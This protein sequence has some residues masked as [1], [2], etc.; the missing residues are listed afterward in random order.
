MLG[1]RNLRH[2]RTASINLTLFVFL[3]CLLYLLLYICSRL[4]LGFVFYA[5]FFGWAFALFCTTLNDV[6]PHGQMMLPAAVMFTA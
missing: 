1:N 5:A 4:L 6:C 3:S 2:A